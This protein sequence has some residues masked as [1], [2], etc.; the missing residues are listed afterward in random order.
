MKLTSID[1]LIFE[2][3]LFAIQIEFH[4]VYW[5][6]IA[7]KQNESHAMLGKTY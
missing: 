2:N 5:L 6:S 4:M 7:H 1:L 3:T